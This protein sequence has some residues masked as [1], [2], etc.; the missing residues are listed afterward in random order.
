M[1]RAG[2]GSVKQGVGAGQGGRWVGG[3]VHAFD[4]ML[5]DGRPGHRLLVMVRALPC[6]L[7]YSPPPLHHPCRSPAGRGRY[8]CAPPKFPTYESER[9]VAAVTKRYRDLYLPGDFV[10]VR[11]LVLHGL[12]AMLH[13]LPA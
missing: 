7:R 6:I 11:K 3:S 10:K 8:S 5:G 2:R 13:F 4:G 1:H 9:G 12:P